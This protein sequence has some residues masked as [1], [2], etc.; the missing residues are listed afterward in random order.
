MDVTETGY[1]PLD[2]Q[3]DY[4]SV[5]LMSPEDV[6]QYVATMLGDVDGRLHDFKT[7]AE[8]KIAWSNDERAWQEL[9]RSMGD[10]K[11]GYSLGEYGTPGYAERRDAMMEAVTKL[12]ESSNPDVAYA[13]NGIKK[14]I[15]DYEAKYQ[16]FVDGDGP[17]PG[18]VLWGQDTIDDAMSA[19]TQRLQSFSSDNE[20]TMMELG[21]LMQRRTQ[22]VQFS[23][24]VMAQ[25]DRAQNSVVQN[26][27]S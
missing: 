7:E 19:S 16:D 5:E 1:K 9:L 21:S 27:G 10:G 4:E 24:N 17:K 3:L 6:L 15:E 8:R 23:T 25:L 14:L 13:G 26:I 11:G 12:A 18:P 22:I 2:F 20:L